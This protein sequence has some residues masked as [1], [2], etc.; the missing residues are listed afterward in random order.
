MLEP[1]VTTVTGAAREKGC[2]RQAI[3]N[4]IERGDLNIVPLGGLSMVARDEKYRAYHV[5]ATGGRLHRSY[6]EK[7][8]EREG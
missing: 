3:Y 7:H 5:Q 4:A 1:N 2:S 6:Q 8:Q